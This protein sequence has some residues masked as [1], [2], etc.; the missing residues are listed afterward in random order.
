MTKIVKR[1]KKKIKDIS[2]SRYS[3]TYILVDSD[4]K[5]YYESQDD[6]VIP[7]RDN[8]RLHQVEL[9]EQGRLDLI[10]YRYYNTTHLWWVIAKASDIYNPLEVKEGDI[11]R[12]P[13]LDSIYGYRG[14]MGI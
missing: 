7:E 11:L 9:S 4:G 10:S 2:N 8:D 14:V 12:I 5:E 1:Y 3:D 6:I 13:T